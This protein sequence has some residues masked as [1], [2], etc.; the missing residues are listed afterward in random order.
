M[1]ELDEEEE[2]DVNSVAGIG[3]SSTIYRMRIWEIF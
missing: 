1:L 2:L 3:T